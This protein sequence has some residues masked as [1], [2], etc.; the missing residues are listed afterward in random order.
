MPKID[1]NDFQKEEP[2]SKIRECTIAE[3]RTEDRQFFIEEEGI[4]FDVIDLDFDGKG[5]GMEVFISFLGED[6]KMRCD[7]V[8][9]KTFES[10]DIPDYLM[11]L[12]E[13][14]KP[15]LECKTKLLDK[16]CREEDDDII[17]FLPED[18]EEA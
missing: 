2:Q 6:F 16:F 9:K 4:I 10:Y 12:L 3:A 5:P 18:D 13:E 14:F 11:S 15:C 17:E 7:L 1:F 8:P